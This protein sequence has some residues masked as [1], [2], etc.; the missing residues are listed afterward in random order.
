MSHTIYDTIVD[1]G[2]AIFETGVE[3][4]YL[5]FRVSVVA[6]RKKTLELRRAPLQSLLV[7]F[8]F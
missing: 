8:P 6:L 3:S 2:I 1:T 4:V 5:S 7:G